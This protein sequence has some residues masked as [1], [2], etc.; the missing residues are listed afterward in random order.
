[1]ISRPASATVLNLLPVYIMEGQSLFY[2]FICLSYVLCSSRDT[3]GIQDRMKWC[4][5]MRQAGG[6]GGIREDAGIY[7]GRNAHLQPA[8][9][10]WPCP[11][12]ASLRHRDASCVALVR[13]SSLGSLR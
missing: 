11:D 10:G 13:S 8:W 3:L 12:I 7:R 9:H 4:Q 2:I 1:M 5:G 6:P